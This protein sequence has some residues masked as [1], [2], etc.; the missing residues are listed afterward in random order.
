MPEKVAAMAVLY[1][2]WADRVGVKTWVGRQTPIGWEDPK[3]YAR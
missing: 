2:E 3:H 1:K